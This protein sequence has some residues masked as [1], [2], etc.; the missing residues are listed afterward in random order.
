MQ[1]RGVY[2]EAKKKYCI[3]VPLSKKKDNLKFYTYQCLSTIGVK[4]LCYLRVDT[5]RKPVSLTIFFYNDAN[6][7]AAGTSASTEL[8][9]SLIRFSEVCNSSVLRLKGF[10]LDNYM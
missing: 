1:L 9:R 6:I 3:L 8:P 2:A 4:S 7:L 10:R 5:K